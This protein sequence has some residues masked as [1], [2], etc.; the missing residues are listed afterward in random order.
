MEKIV[1][2]NN[3]DTLLVVE[4]FIQVLCDKYHINNNVAIVT[5]PVMQ[6]VDFALRSS[7]RD[8]VVMSD[9]YHD[10]VFF[11]VMSSVPCFPSS[12]ETAL[13]SPTSDSSLFLIQ[14]LADKVEVSKEGKSVKMFFAIQGINIKESAQRKNVLMSFGEPCSLELA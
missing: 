10:G 2:Q 9:Y 11:M 3:T 5:I 12:L 8:V 1:I 7:D 13:P 6:A 14:Q 4:N